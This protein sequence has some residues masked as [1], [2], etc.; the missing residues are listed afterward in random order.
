MKTRIYI[1]IVV[2]VLLTGG[3]VSCRNLGSWLAKEDLPEHADVMIML[4]GGTTERSLQTADH[5]HENLSGKIWIVE[6]GMDEDRA[7]ELR[8][9]VKLR[10]SSQA[11]YALMGLGV[12]SDSIIILPGAANSTRMEAEIVREHLLGQSGVDTLLLVSS[13]FHTRRAS[14]IFKSALHPLEESPA[15][16]CSP[17]KYGRFRAEKWWASKR[18]AYWVALES[19]KLANFYLFEKWALRKGR[20]GMTE[21]E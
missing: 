15:L 17:S 7:L 3:V 6:A 11:R 21:K 13:P 12:P 20:T 8:G 2:V 1:G 19:M 4:M 16:Y 18:D 14:L 10:T 9:I 5:Y